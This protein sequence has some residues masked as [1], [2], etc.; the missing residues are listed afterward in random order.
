MKEQLLYFYRT[1]HQKPGRIIFYRDGV[2][3]GQF[4]EVCVEVV[5]RAVESELEGIF[6]WSRSREKCTDS[7]S[8]LSL[9][10]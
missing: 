4:R 7:N 10:S 3:E 9:K 6:R 1:A 8:D 5:S 2:S